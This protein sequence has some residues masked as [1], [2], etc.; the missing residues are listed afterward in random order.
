[1]DKK[2]YFTLGC[3]ITFASAS[4][5]FLNPEEFNRARSTERSPTSKELI[6]QQR[7]ERARTYKSG[8]EFRAEYYKAIRMPKINQDPDYLL[9]DHPIEEH[10]LQ[11]QNVR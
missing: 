3:L 7:L 11:E 6:E 4:A 9:E 1:M 2:I 5:V 10:T 8:A